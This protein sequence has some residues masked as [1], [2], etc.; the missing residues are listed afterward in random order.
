M[1]TGSSQK[2]VRQCSTSLVVDIKAILKDTAH[3]AGW[4]KFQKTFPNVSKDVDC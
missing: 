3:P 1:L 2:N 4:L